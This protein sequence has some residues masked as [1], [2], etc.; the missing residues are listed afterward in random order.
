MQL[1]LIVALA[2]CVALTGCTSDTADVTASAPSPYQVSGPRTWG[3]ADNVM[4]IKHLYISRQPDPVGITEAGRDGV[5][6]VV[7]SRLPGETDWDQKAAV[8]AAG[9]TYYNVP[10]SREGDSLD[11]DTMHRLTAIVSQHRDEQILMY[12]GSGNRVSAWL[13]THL[14]E[15]HGLGEDEA[16]AIAHETGLTKPALEQRVRNYLDQVA[17]GQ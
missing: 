9:M 17:P 8:E 7:N 16:L 15:D 12:C 13:A 6:V 14:V 2:I 4:Q 1:R 11:A 10:I 3:A 5:G